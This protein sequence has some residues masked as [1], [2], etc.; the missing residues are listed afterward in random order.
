VSDA[1]FIKQ[2]AQKIQNIC[3]WHLG[4]EG[5]NVKADKYVVWIDPENVQCEDKVLRILHM[6]CSFPQTCPQQTS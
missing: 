2:L 5:D 3:N 4:E 1:V 6:M